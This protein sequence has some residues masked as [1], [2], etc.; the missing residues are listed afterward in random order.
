MEAAAAK[1]G[2]LKLS[3]QLLPDQKINAAANYTVADER[4]SQGRVVNTSASLRAAVMTSR[5]EFTFFEEELLNEIN[6][7]RQNPSAYAVL[8]EKVATVG[9]PYI[10]PDD[11]YFESDERV[12]D[13]FHS[14]VA[15]GP[16]VQLE[17]N[18]SSARNYR[19]TDHHNTSSAG[20]DDDDSSRG[21]IQSAPYSAK[22]SS[23]GTWGEN[24]GYTPS[25]DGG[26][27]SSR[28]SNILGT[29]TVAECG[30]TEMN[31]EQ[32]RIFLARHQ[33]HRVQLEKA[34][35][36]AI[37]EWQTSDLAQ[38]EA[39]ASEDAQTVKKTRRSRKK[40]GPA[41]SPDEVMRYRAQAAEQLSHEYLSKLKS[42]MWRLCESRDTCSRAVEGANLILDCIRGLK[43]AKPVPPLRCSRGLKLAARD[44]GQFFHRDA[45]ETKRVLQ[46]HE[47]AMKWIFP[48][49]M[50]AERRGTEPSVPTPTFDSRNASEAMRYYE[51]L[52]G[53]GPRD[54]FNTTVSLPQKPLQDL[55]DYIHSLTDTVQKAC[56]VYGYVSGEVRGVQLY[57]QGSARS[58]I[59]K[60]LLGVAVPVFGFR[61]LRQAGVTGLSTTRLSRESR[62]FSLPNLPS[63]RLQPGPELKADPDDGTMSGAQFEDS[64][65]YSCHQREEKELTAKENPPKC[66]LQWTEIKEAH[67][68]GAGG[69]RGGG[70]AESTQSTTGFVFG[71]T[72]NPTTEEA[73]AALNTEEL[74]ENTSAGKRA[75]L[76]ARRLGP[77][78]W[79]DAHLLG[80]GW[81]RVVPEKA[82]PNY[83]NHNADFVIP[84][85]TSEE[86]VLV[87]TTLVL[88]SGYEE[89]DLIER[90]KHM[91]LQEVRRIVRYE[92]DQGPI[93]RLEDNHGSVVLGDVRDKCRDRPAV[94]DLHSSLGVSLLY[95]TKHPVLIESGMK[96]AWLALRVDPLR[97]NIVASVTGE[98]EGKPVTPDLSSTQV[99]KMNSDRDFNV[100]LILVNVASA[101]TKCSGDGKVLIHIFELEKMG[102]VEQGWEHIGFVRL[103]LQECVN[104]A[105]CLNASRAVETSK[106]SLGVFSPSAIPIGF[107]PLSIGC[108]SPAKS[109]WVTGKRSTLVPSR[110]RSATTVGLGIPNTAVSS[111]LPQPTMV[112]HR[113]L[114]TMA[115][116]ELMPLLGDLRLSPHIAPS[117]E[118]S[119]GA[120]A[121]TWGLT[122]WPL[123]SFEFFE[124]CGTLIQPLSG[125]LK[126][127]N[128]RCRMTVHFPVYSSFLEAQLQSLRKLEAELQEAEEE[129]ED[130]GDY[131]EEI[132][133]ES[134]LISLPSGVTSSPGGKGKKKGVE[135]PKH[136][137]FGT[138]TNPQGIETTLLSSLKPSNGAGE[139]E[140]LE[141]LVE[142]P[143]TIAD[144]YDPS[145]R[146][147]LKRLQRMSEK[148]AEEA[149]LCRSKY[150]HAVEILEPLINEASA[151][152]EKRK[153]KENQRLTQERE[154]YATALETM[155][156][157]V[158]EVETIEIHIRE[159]IT[160]RERNRVVRRIRLAQLR[161]ELDQLT[162]RKN[163][164]K[165]LDVQLSFCSTSGIFGMNQLGPSPPPLGSAPL[166]LQ[167]S[168]SG[169]ARGEALNASCDGVGLP[170]LSLPVEDS[171]VV[172]LAPK[173]DE[174]TLYE[175]DFVVPDGFEGTA[176]L[177]VNDQSLV[178][179]RVLPK[180]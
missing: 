46:A 77:F 142:L 72:F 152:A 36:Q 53:C 179:W 91:R 165:P 118:L 9:Y 154:L 58:L 54:A 111:R 14:R 71:G 19:R 104:S 8:F 133:A 42:L 16:S 38:H 93:G 98:E 74:G 129:E 52:F 20:D 81:Q 80:C 119:G 158:L 67:A 28:T 143:T 137:K 6:L 88:A 40:S 2:K 18:R 101:K 124:S 166:L 60:V 144:R 41:L 90:H 31:L 78:L 120:E 95:P 153:S 26:D 114:M 48:S 172:V 135:K 49:A 73:S 126:N 59:M 108:S 167:S 13:P 45:D 145:V 175:A 105:P 164:E 146:F 138:Q 68:G 83:D 117:V 87:C 122:G 27:D 130:V 109:S 63:G 62:F 85:D 123:I 65:F 24:S 56:D 141:D 121:E 69:V 37:R 7:L 150:N 96:T 89:L 1:Q 140:S 94:V 23:P 106:H 99:L 156:R 39:W 15:Q 5:D 171:N 177:R 116:E 35:R 113:G 12:T 84:Q 75:A 11:L 25:L 47:A 168:N 32:L 51:E 155:R 44:T 169:Y 100:T 22:S 139:V 127:S 128:E 61:E 82:V 136:N 107:T 134:P 132:A 131:Y 151:A 10:R 50:A 17:T 176:V 102:G 34:V 112:L 30:V 79:R 157:K 159:E 43:E 97:V 149:Q 64:I 173:N 160:V 3:S 170:P 4:D 29:P 147:H 110:Q 174:W 163:R 55:R 70:L 178:I 66:P 21:V 125:C 162:S 86:D 103:T 76:S 92:A 33:R 115:P 161:F 148:I 180:Q 57:G